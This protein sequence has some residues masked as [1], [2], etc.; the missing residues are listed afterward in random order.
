VWRKLVGAFGNQAA[1]DADLGQVGFVAVFYAGQMLD[2]GRHPLEHRRIVQP[3][4][5]EG[6]EE[7]FMENVASDQAGL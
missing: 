7:V 6:D 1:E 3:L 5:Y 2:I 4:D